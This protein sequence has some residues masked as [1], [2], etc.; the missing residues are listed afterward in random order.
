LASRTVWP[1]IRGLP[2][3]P[4]GIMLSAECGYMPTYIHLQQ[5]SKVD[6]S[7]LVSAFWRRI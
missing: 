6:K 1:L 2:I 3:T 4:P 5:H 7:L